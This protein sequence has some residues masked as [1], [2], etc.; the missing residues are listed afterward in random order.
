[1]VEPRKIF[2]QILQNTS[3]NPIQDR[4]IRIRG[5]KRNGKKIP[6]PIAIKT[7]IQ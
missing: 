2:S 7:E 6:I 1:V 5:S 4:K 3:L